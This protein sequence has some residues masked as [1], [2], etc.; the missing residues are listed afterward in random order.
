MKILLG[1]TFRTFYDLPLSNLTS[2]PRGF[3]SA[4]SKMARFVA[5]AN[6]LCLEA[7]FIRSLPAGMLPSLQT[8]SCI[9]QE[10]YHPPTHTPWNSHIIYALVACYM[11]TYCMWL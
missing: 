2:S 4:I 10:D 11:L 8:S 5:L 1:L 6:F 3:V 9:H 7:P